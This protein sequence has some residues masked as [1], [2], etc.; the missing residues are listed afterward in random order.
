MAESS[1]KNIIGDYEILDLIGKGAQGDV[2]KAVCISRSNP[3]VPYG[4]TVALKKG[5]AE[6]GEETK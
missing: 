4:E 6:A 3:N 2:Y 1:S 5:R